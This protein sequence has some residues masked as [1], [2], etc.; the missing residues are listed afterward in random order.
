L[1]LPLTGVR[2]TIWCTYRY[3][4]CSRKK[5]STFVP[6]VQR[7]LLSISWQVVVEESMYGAAGGLAGTVAGDCSALSR[8]GRRW[9]SDIGRTTSSPPGSRGTHACCRASI[10]DNRAGCAPAARRRNSGVAQRSCV[11]PGPSA[12]GWLWLVATGA[13][14]L[15]MRCAAHH[16]LTSDTQSSHG[17]PGRY[18][19]LPLPGPSSTASCWSA[20]RWPADPGAFVE[21]TVDLLSSGILRYG[22]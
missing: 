1:P 15:K 9:S 16:R 21:E 12:T 5:P 13:P 18:R 19:R 11:L 20:G 4:R 17:R 22:L 6:A 3:A 14:Q 10:R 8:T 2:I 7:C